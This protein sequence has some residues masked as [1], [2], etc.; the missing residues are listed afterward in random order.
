M[1][2]KSTGSGL[3]PRVQFTASLQ[4]SGAPGSVL[5][6]FGRTGIVTAQAGDYTAAQVTNAVSTAG[7]YNDPAWITGLSWS[8]LVGTAPIAAFQTPW[9]QPINANSNALTNVPSVTG[10]GNLT[11]A[12]GE[13]GTVTLQTSAKSRMTIDSAGH[14]TINTPDDTTAPGLTVNSNVNANS[15]QATTGNIIST[16]SGTATASVMVSNGTP[17]YGELMLYTDNNVYVASNSSV[18]V[19]TGGNLTAL[20]TVNKNRL[21]VDSAG[22]VTINT[23]DDTA[24][25][26]LVNGPLNLGPTETGT[27]TPVLTFGGASTGITYAAQSGQ[28][29][30]VNGITTVFIYIVLSSKG[31]ATGSMTITG[32]P[33]GGG[34]GYKYTATVV[35][36][37]CAGLVGTTFGQIYPAETQIRFG[38]QTATGITAGIS[39]AN[40]TNGT[41]IF[42]TLTYKS[43]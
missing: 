15:L 32:L 27:F 39:D 23:P 25:A 5:S 29:S 21:Q 9:L 38:Q 11:V 2:T 12:A 22:H 37:G 41:Q 16:V 13:A 40:V 20:R 4:P 35:M 30:R 42:V 36:D 1:Q 10:N 24:T 17:Y 33:F 19:G 31:S 18:I 3:I 26:L 28:Y 14:V 8:K 43:A 7:S 34:A 6:V